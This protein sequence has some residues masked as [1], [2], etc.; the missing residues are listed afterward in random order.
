MS[1][2]KNN[3]KTLHAL[4]EA[5]FYGATGRIRTG[6]LLITNQLLYRLSHSSVYETF[7]R[8]LYILS[9]FDWV[10]KDFDALSEIF[11]VSC[12]FTVS[13]RQ[14]AAVCLFPHPFRQ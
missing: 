12:Q 1:V 8:R 9:N 10:E 4:H 2:E 14:A 7:A 5:F 13:Y 6:D 3:K 11:F